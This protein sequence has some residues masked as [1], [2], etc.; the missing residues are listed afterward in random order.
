MVL[1]INTFPSHYHITQN[2]HMKLSSSG[3]FLSTQTEIWYLLSNQSQ[4]PW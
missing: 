3:N 2:V 1:T 4:F